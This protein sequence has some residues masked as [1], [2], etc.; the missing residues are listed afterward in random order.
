M[1]QVEK[2][3]A[4]LSA[5]SKE[6][7]QEST[8]LSAEEVKLAAMQDADEIHSKLVKGA[9]AQ[10]RILSK[11]E[12]DLKSLAGE[13]EILRTMEQRLQSMAKELG[14]DLDVDYASDA[15]AKALSRYA[16]EVGVIANKL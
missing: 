4:E 1:K 10:A 7:V 15:W 3:W 16:N 2:I 13:A 12:N 14:V 5:K 8:E 6:A 11:V 9:Q